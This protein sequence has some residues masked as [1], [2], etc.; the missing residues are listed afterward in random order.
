MM[1]ETE[2]GWIFAC[3]YDAMLTSVPLFHRDVRYGI[4]QKNLMKNQQD[5]IWW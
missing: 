5:V 1:N 4:Q 2:S 3:A